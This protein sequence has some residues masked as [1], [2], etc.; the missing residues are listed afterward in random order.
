MKKLILILTVLTLA[1]SFCSTVS[2][3]NTQNNNGVAEFDPFEN[4]DEELSSGTAVGEIFDP[5]EGYNRV[6]YAF[7]DK[8]YHYFLKPVAKGY[9]FVVP[10]PARVSVKRVF[11]NLAMPKRF[12]NCLLQGKLKGAGTELA[13]FSINTTFGLGGLF[14][15]AGKCIEDY[16]E[17]SGQTLGHYGIGTGM[18]IVWPFLGP[19]S[20]RGTAGTVLDTVLNPLTYVQ[21]EFWQKL[22]IRGYYTV[23]DTS[24]RLGEYESLKQSAVDPYIALRNAYFQHRQDAL[25]N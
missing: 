22:S 3:E 11:Y 19:S 5:I 7:N 1:I 2:A 20:L 24:L 13:R 23:N 17:D 12:V 4:S 6:M 21:M 14:D 25:N 16:N 9:S 10:K 8:L 18:Y 15:P